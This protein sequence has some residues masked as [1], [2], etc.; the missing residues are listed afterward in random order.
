VVVVVVV[1]VVVKM[2]AAVLARNVG[3]H[4]AQR[5]QQSVWGAR[6]EAQGAVD[7]GAYSSLRVC[8]EQERTI[9]QRNLKKH[10]NL[11]EVAH[12]CSA[13]EI[14]YHFFVTSGKPL[15]VY[16]TA[17]KVYEFTKHAYG[18][19]ESQPCHSLQNIFGLERESRY[20]GDA[21]SGID[22]PM[23]K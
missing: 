4:R 10:I 11:L 18:F 3:T 2:V 23:R 20:F 22:G 8:V 15:K 13:W 6:I 17:L 16:A 19:F 1:V 21:F 5:L 14:Y 7:Y 12:R 9:A